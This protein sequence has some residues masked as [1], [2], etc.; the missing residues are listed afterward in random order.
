MFKWRRSLWLSLHRVK[1]GE[2]RVFTRERP[3]V[4]RPTLGKSFPLRRHRRRTSLVSHRRIGE[5]VF[6][7]CRP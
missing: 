1:Y 2:T 3:V 7:G 5:R 4:E 6:T